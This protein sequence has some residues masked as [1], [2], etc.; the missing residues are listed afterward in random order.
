MKKILFVVAISLASIIQSQAQVSFKPGLRGGVNMSKI[1]QTE[2]SFKADF[3][4]GV[5]GALKLG[6][7]YTLQPEIIYSNQGGKDIEIQEY[8]FETN[9]TTVSF[10]TITISYVSVGII[11]KF[12]FNDH[13]N[14]HLGP[15]FDIQTGRNIYSNSEVD[16]AFI[17]GLGYNVTNN[18]AIEGRIK[19]GLVD[20]LDS[21]YTSSNSPFVGSYNTNFLFQLGLSYTFD[22]QN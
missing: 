8:N 1:T 18:L 17:A 9:Q 6:S 4:V 2:S 16:I 21:D 19:K 15:L 14:F 3:Y 11:N 10:E 7:L 12:N 5:Y 20:V 22:I 13:V